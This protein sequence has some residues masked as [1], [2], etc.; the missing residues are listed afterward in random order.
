MS[1]S[2][3]CAKLHAT[4]LAI[5]PFTCQVTVGHIV[6]LGNEIGRSFRIFSTYTLVSM[7]PSH[8]K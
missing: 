7:H 8:S 5:S 6:E 1:L 2:T 3:Y 4:M